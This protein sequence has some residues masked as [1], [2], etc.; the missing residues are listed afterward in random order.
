MASNVPRLRIL[1]AR[2]FRKMGLPL[3]TFFGIGVSALLFNAVG[4]LIEA[5][6]GWRMGAKAGSLLPALILCS[7]VGIG[8]AVLG[9][10]ISHNP[11]YA[12]T[13]DSRRLVDPKKGLIFLVSKQKPAELAI[14]RHAS[15]G[16][17]LRHVWLLPSRED[18]DLFGPSTSQI[19]LDIKQWCSTAFPDVDVKILGVAAGDAQDTFDHVNRIFRNSGLVTNDIVADFTGGLKPMSVGMIMACLPAERQ[20]EYIA[21]NPATNTSSG[22]YLIDYQ[23]SAFDLVG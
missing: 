3:W 17:P 15:G 21:F 13:M 7:V 8:V 16:G 1:L 23:H 14:S 5:F 12:G 22:P 10:W 19:A 20:L 11:Y 2:V 18:D 6:V 4:D 9:V